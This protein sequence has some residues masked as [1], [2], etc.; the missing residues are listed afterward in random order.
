MNKLI[1]IVAYVTETPERSTHVLGGIL[2]L[3]CSARSLYP[4]TVTW[5][6]SKFLYST[7][8]KTDSHETEGL[9]NILNSTI[10]VKISLVTPLSFYLYCKFTTYFYFQPDNFTKVHGLYQ[11]GLLFEKPIPRNVYYFYYNDE[12]VITI[13][14]KST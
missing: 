11:K 9:Y 3:K 8:V 2:T 1:F 6:E 12:D 10:S 14:R 7:I 5:E 4:M 13:Q